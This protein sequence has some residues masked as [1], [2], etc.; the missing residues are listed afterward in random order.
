[1]ILLVLT[2]AGYFQP[3]GGF[4]LSLYPLVRCYDGSTTLRFFYPTN[5]PALR[6]RLRFPVLVAINIQ[7]G[8][9]IGLIASGRR[10]QLLPPLAASIPRL[11]S[12]R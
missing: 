7:R 10:F 1:M 4:R 2:L 12:Y 6:L 5:F 11:C 8:S 9:I 3:R